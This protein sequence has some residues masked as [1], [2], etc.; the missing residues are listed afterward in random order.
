MTD[1]RDEHYSG[2][3]LRTRKRVTSSITFMPTVM[4][5]GATTEKQSSAK[6]RKPTGQTTA[7]MGSHSIHLL[8]MP[9]IVL[10][11]ILSACHT[12]VCGMWECALVC[13]RFRRLYP[14][15]L[16]QYLIHCARGSNVTAQHWLSL[17]SKTGQISPYDSFQF[18]K[19]NLIQAVSGTNSA[20][21]WYWQTMVA[22]HYYS[23]CG[24]DKDRD[25][26][27]LLLEHAAQ[28][29]HGD[30]MVKLGIRCVNLSRFDEALCHFQQPAAQ[31][32]TEIHYGMGALLIKT[33]KYLEAVR[34][35]RAG[36]GKGCPLA[37]HIYGRCLWS[38]SKTYPILSDKAL[39]MLRL[40][41]QQGQFAVASTLQK[42]GVQN[43]DAALA[44][45]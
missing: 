20:R 32:C 2:Y 4:D 14:P 45:P 5:S 35:I 39:W 37:M 22:E 7:D 42:L 25:L 23:G 8:D 36:A 27:I 24:V 43:V 12:S 44:T 11:H 41:Y 15:S 38:A 33:G 28:N 1:P 30:A 13:K 29:G 26:A 9:D 40:A 31:T 19:L 6:R 18:A 3:N 17:L 16:R 21:R 34:E 10:K